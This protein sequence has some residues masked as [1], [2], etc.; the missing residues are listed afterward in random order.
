VWARAQL[1]DVF[2]GE[3]DVFDRTIDSHVKN[4]RKKI[5]QYFPELDL[6]QSVYGIG[7]RLEV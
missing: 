7:Y 6:I 5:A 2:S 3:K 4:I 1:L